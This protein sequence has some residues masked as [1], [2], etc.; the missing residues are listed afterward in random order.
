MELELRARSRARDIRNELGLGDSPIKDIF[1]LIESLN[2]LLFKKPFDSECLSALFLKNSENYII[3][4]NSNKTLGH[5]IYSAAHELS[6]YFFDKDLKGGICSINNT[7]NE[8]EIMADKFAEHFLMPDELVVKELDK[9][10]TEKNYIDV[11]D[12]IYLQHFFCV[13][14][15]AI[16]VKLEKLGYIKGKYEY[17]NVGIRSLTKALGYDEKLVNITKDKYVSKKYLEMALKCYDN[18]EISEKKLDEYLNDVDMSIKDM[19]LNWQ[20]NGEEEEFM[21]E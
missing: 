9:R 6:H 15:T 12:I 10:L 21:Y 16:L 1:G 7:K 13:S 3:V 8:I 5:Q 14:W 20:N 17:M 2:I 4:I 18:Y 19:S 11:F